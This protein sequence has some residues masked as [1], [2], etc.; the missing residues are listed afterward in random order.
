MIWWI[1][2]KVIYTYNFGKFVKFNSSRMHNTKSEQYTPIVKLAK[3]VLI[4]N[5]MYILTFQNECQPKGNQN[6]PRDIKIAL[7]RIWITSL[8]ISHQIMFFIAMI[9]DLIHQEL[10]LLWKFK[11]QRIVTFQIDLTITTQVSVAF[12][13][14]LCLHVQTYIQGKI[15]LIM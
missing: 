7:Q 11:D 4:A 9:H 15:K 2:L 6:T 12:L 10:H 13:D 8:S 14:N 1:C 5:G 3:T